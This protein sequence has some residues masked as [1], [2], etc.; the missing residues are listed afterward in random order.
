MHTPNSEAGDLPDDVGATA[1]I[2]DLSHPA[3]PADPAQLILL[4]EEIAVWA[5]R[6]GLRPEQVSDVQLAVYEAMA[7]VVVHTYPEATGT[8]AVHRHDDLAPNWEH[9][10]RPKPCGEY[11]RS[12]TGY[13]RA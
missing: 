4:R 10:T 2:A 1:R 8:L 5:S 12:N 9:L 3:I 13:S 6:A 7:N 11:E